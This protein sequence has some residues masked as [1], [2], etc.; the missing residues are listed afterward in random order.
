MTLNEM[1]PVRP[2]L[3]HCRQCDGTGH[4]PA[5]PFRTC[6]ECGGAGGKVID[7]WPKGHGVYFEPAGS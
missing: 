4:E 6:G 3:S 2:L 7:P 1:K 5:N